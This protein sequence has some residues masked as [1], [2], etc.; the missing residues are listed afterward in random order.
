MSELKENEKDTDEL[1]LFEFEEDDD[2]DVS[3]DSF[4]KYNNPQFGLPAEYEAKLSL[5]QQELAEMKSKVSKFDLA[6]K[7]ADNMAEMHSF[8]NHFAD[9][10]DRIKTYN[11][12]LIKKVNSKTYELLNS[13]QNEI[14]SLKEKQEEEKIHRINLAKDIVSMNDSLFLEKAA[15]RSLEDT[16]GNID[17]IDKKTG[18]KKKLGQQQVDAALRFFGDR[19]QTEARF[20][21]LVDNIYRDKQLTPKGLNKKIGVLITDTFKQKI[22]EHIKNTKKNPEKKET[23][24]PSKKSTDSSKSSENEEQK[25]LTVEE[26]DKLR[27]ERR[28]NL[29]RILKNKKMLSTSS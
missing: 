6:I 15:R 5:T 26:K 7:E 22:E 13:L 11:K 8:E 19:Y 21:Q 9:V 24:E 20:A 4:K 27:E 16:F 14:N 3:K 12:E 17:I 28:N 23:T 2:E 1:A 10:D 29:E 18:Q 25:E